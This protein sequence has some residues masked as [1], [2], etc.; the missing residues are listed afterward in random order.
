MTRFDRFDRLPLVLNVAAAVA[1]SA[2]IAYWA[3]QL[4]RPQQ[5][6]LAAPPPAVRPEPQAL[7][8]T[9]LFGGSQAVSAAA[10]NYQLT[11]VV[12]AGRDSVAIIVVDGAKA[13]S[14]PLGKEVAPGVRVVEVYPRYVMLSEGGVAKRI[15]L[16]QQAAPSAGSGATASPS[17]SP[18][19]PAAPAA[20]QPL[21]VV[22]AQPPAPGVAPVPIPGAI[23][24]APTA[25]PQ[26]PSQPPQQQDL[27][28]LADQARRQ[29]EALGIR[30][31]AQ[32]PQPVMGTGVAPVTQPPT[33]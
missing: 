22:P 4:Y 1:L 11:G 10:S 20:V 28:G 14:V 8:A 29:Q 24:M 23:D 27:G 33:Q 31:P 5:R 3:M 6:P 15:D 21:P 17:I 7:A 19:Q 18:I 26:D 12:A 25:P 32:M 13:R 30:P 9:S 2:S 16:A